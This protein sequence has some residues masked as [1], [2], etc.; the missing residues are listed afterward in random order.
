MSYMAEYSKVDV[1]LSQYA[2]SNLALVLAIANGVSAIEKHLK[3][4]EQDFCPDTSFLIH[5]D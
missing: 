2:T 1:G 5:P 3:L 4:D